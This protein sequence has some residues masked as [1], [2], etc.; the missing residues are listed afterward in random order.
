MMLIKISLNVIHWIF[1]QTSA[2]RQCLPVPQ[3]IG[4]HGLRLAGFVVLAIYASGLHLGAAYNPQWKHMNVP[5][6][7]P[8]V[9]AQ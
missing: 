8:S 5:S 1:G 4:A 7:Q 3:G 2:C 6:T 9:A